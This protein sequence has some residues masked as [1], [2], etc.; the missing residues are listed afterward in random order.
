MRRAAVSILLFALAFSAGK[1]SHAQN[2]ISIPM[3]GT[4]PVRCSAQ[5]TQ[6]EVDASGQTPFV[7]I[8]VA[9]ACNARNNL[10][11]SLPNAA[12]QNYVVM[13][14]YGGQAPSAAS[15]E[16]ITFVMP[17]PIAGTRQ[18]ILN[19]SGGSEEDAQQLAS[20]LQIS[21]VAS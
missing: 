10:V 21:V 7:R 6:I 3:Q 9:H 16:Q 20:G 8:T 11:V 2:S 15:A 5:A 17:G 12:P 13:A 1:P 4:L 19:L 18:L 14:T